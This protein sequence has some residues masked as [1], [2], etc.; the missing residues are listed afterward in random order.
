MKYAC[1]QSHSVF[2][3]SKQFRDTEYKQQKQN[4]T[5]TTIVIAFPEAKHHGYEFVS[6]RLLSEY[7]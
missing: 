6:P 1:I 3:E 7:T 2:L 4:V 5:I